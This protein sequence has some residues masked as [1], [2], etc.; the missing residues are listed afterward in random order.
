MEVTVNFR[1]KIIFSRLFS[2]VDKNVNLQLVVLRFHT[3]HIRLII[4]IFTKEDHT[5]M[6]VVKQMRSATSF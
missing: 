2:N 3:I 4:V 6:E 1:L 5:L